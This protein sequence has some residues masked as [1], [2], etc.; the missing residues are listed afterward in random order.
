MASLRYFNRAINP[1]EVYSIYKRGP[2]ELGLGRKLLP[3][4]NIS[5]GVEAAQEETSE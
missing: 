2:E 5:F 1:E 4:I 3:N